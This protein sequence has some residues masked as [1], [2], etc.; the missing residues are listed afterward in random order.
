VFF[1]TGLHEDYHA[2]SDDLDKI[3]LE[4]MAAVAEAAAIFIQLLANSAPPT[5][6]PESLEK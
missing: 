6:N 1:F 4:G 5:F 2:P 3:D